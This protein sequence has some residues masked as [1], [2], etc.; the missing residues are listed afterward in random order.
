MAADDNAIMIFCTRVILMNM[1]AM[2]ETYQDFLGWI[3][4]RNGNVESI[5]DFGGDG[6][7]AQLQNPIP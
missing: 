5:V 6:L 1:I 3:L 7:M 2:R 4:S